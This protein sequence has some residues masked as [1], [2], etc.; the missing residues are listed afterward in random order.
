M[1]EG[2]NHFS[3]FHICILLALFLIAGTGVVSAHAPLDAGSNEDL[4]NATLVSPPEKSFVIYTELHESGEAQYYR[5]PME[6]GQILYGS[7]QVPGT[8]SMIPDLAIIGPGI[9]SSGDI[10][11]FVDVPPGSAATV[12]RGRVP[13]HPSYEPFS[14]QPIYEVAR[15]NITVPEGG[16]YY[17]AVFG[18]SGGKYSLAPGFLEEF[19]PAEW[20]LIPWS[21]ITIHLWEGQS[22]FL[23]LSPLIAVLIGGIALIT[24]ARKKKGMP[25]GPVHWLI[26]TAGLLYIG[27]AAMTALQIVFTVSVTGYDPSIFLTLFFLGIPLLLGL[28]AVRAGFTLSRRDSGRKTGVILIMT[29]LLGLLFWAGLIIGP[30]LAIAGGVVLL[31]GLVSPIKIA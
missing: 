11:P 7:L 25:F 26:V 31:S 10:P 8:T 21:V 2:F 18:N 15:F 3:G 4:S 29:G 14:P 16:T 22:L 24:V 13:E 19:T 1:A 28:I 9:A 17:I 23:I 20:L 5:F 30:V 27:G 12:I 6:K